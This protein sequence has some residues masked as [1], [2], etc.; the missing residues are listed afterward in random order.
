MPSGSNSSGRGTQSRCAGANY[1]NRK[2]EARFLA[3]T[4]YPACYLWF[5]ALFQK[6]AN[7]L[8]Q[9]QCALKK[10][11]G[12]K[13]TGESAEEISR[14]WRVIEPPKI[15]N[16]RQSINVD[17]LRMYQLHQSR[18]PVRAAQAALLHTAPG[19]LRDSVGIEDFVDHYG[20][21]INSFRQPATACDVVRPN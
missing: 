5:I 17:V 15:G 16:G 9:Q 13:S 18:S 7:H 12:S 20:T 4:T 6:P 10:R 2:R 3:D 1:H 14:R 19:I 11:S 21:G 8:R